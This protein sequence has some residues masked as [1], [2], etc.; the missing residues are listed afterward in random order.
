VSIER[1]EIIHFNHKSTQQ[2]DHKMDL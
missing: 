2:K 1:L